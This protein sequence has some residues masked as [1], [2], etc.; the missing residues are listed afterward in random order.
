MFA[1]FHE[2]A[3]ETHFDNLQLTWI[4]SSQRPHCDI[5]RYQVHVH[6]SSDGGGLLQLDVPDAAPRFRLWR[7]A[8]SRRIR[9]INWAETAKKWARFRHCMR[10]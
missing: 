7:R 1:A 6:I 10:L 4:D 2:S 9:L 5:E 8:C 3:K